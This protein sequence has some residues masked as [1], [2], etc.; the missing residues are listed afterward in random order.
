[1]FASFMAFT[2]F[3]LLKRTFYGRVPTFLSFDRV[4][5]Q[6]SLNKVSNQTLS[7]EISHVKKGY[8]ITDAAVFYL[9]VFLVE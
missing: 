7:K 5:Y 2:D 6:S 1:M 8:H 9:K 4:S 3:S